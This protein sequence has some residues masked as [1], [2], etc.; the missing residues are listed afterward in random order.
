MGVKIAID[1][2]THFLDHLGNMTF[3]VA[4]A[5]RAWVEKED[6][7]NTMPLKDLLKW[8]HRKR[9]ARGQDD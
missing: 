5:R 4:V 3:G 1:T 7:V 8:A 2:D 6:V 9:K